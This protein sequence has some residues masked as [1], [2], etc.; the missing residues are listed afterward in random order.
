MVEESIPQL[1]QG[2]LKDGQGQGKGAAG[3]VLGS[4]KRKEA[5]ITGDTLHCAVTRTQVLFVT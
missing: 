5:G 1:F 3:Q 2:Q 4:S